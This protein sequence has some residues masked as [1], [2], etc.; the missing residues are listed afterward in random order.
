MHSLNGFLHDLTLN[1]V[2][3][4]GVYNIHS[5]G[6]LSFVSPFRVLVPVENC[7]GTHTRFYTTEQSPEVLEYT[8]STGEK[9]PY[10]LYDENHCTEVHCLELNQPILIDVRKPHGVNNPLKSY[11]TNLW[12]DFNASFTP[13]ASAYIES[14]HRAL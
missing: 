6:E 11:R 3:H 2:G 5:D 12:L 1:V 4:Q 14:S 8:T 7:I 13:F 9:R 10:Y